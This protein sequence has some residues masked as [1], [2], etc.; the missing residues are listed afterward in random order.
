VAEARVREKAKLERPKDWEH[1]LY[2]EL[3]CGPVFATV[4]E[5]TASPRS[6]IGVVFCPPF[7]WAELCV[8]RSTRAWAEKLAANG[9]TAL[10]LD[11]PG[12]GDSAGAPRD[13]AR[14]PAWMAAAAGAAAWLR[15]SES[16]ERI[17]AIGIGLG[18]MIALAAIGDGAPIDDA[19]LWAVPRRGGLLLRELRTFAQM[20][21]NEDEIDAHPT[22]SLATHEWLEIAG[23][24]LSAETVRDLEA[25]D[26]TA[27]PVPDAR[28]RRFLLLGRD[29]L[30]ADQRLRKHLEASG[31]SVVAADG[32]GYGRMVTHPQL[33]VAPTQVFERS[34]SWLGQ[35]ALSPR[36]SSAVEIAAPSSA[37]HVKLLVGESKIRESPFSVEFEGGR[38][39][40]VLAR[41]T[42]GQADEARLCA[43]LLN[44]GAVRRIGP[45]RMWVEIARRWAAF[46]VPTLRI[47][48]ACFG[49]SDGDERRYYQ[50]SEF[51]RDNSLE[52]IRTVLDSLEE[53][54]LPSSFLLAGLCSSAYWGVR[55]ALADSRVSA[56]VLVNLWSFVWSEELA[57]GRDARRARALL[58][59]GSWR[60]VA[61]IAASEGRIGRF[62]R[63]TLRRVLSGERS[64]GDIAEAVAAET[65]LMLDKLDARD[66]ET[67]LLLSGSEPLAEDFEA[68]GRLERLSRWPRLSYERIPIDD[69][70]FR[71]LWAQHYVNEAFDGAL[72][73]ALGRVTD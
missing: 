16:C 17:V 58:R 13:P 2:L 4:H 68:D 67:L 26:L 48:G 69:H 10:R 5:P 29:T 63:I 55:A 53:E 42:G 49:D 66:V 8:H 47:D 24:G 9:H 30:A 41:P 51:Y 60:D 18:G 31:A 20:A 3:D 45:N 27:I 56:L 21:S 6:G 57:A 72:R 50:T 32:P 73:R 46:G 19:V 15:A 43:V 33:A 39:T 12:S 11:F 14:L 22:D 28:H 1:A 59:S 23:F 44:A 62:A 70:I 52:Q 40:G 64:G 61:R 38:L 35:A 25:L 54:G 65:D 7:G 37:R 36:P 71:P 34:L